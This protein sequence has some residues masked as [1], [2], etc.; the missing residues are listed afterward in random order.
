[1]MEV[2]VL[3]VSLS[4]LVIAGGMYIEWQERRRYRKEMKY[5]KWRDAVSEIIRYRKEGLSVRQISKLTGIPK[6]T[7][8]EY[9]KQFL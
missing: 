6:S 9:I 8:H 1:M 4:G 5:L 3:I 7:I 2:A